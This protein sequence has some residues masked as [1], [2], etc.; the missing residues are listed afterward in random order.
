MPIKVLSSAV[1]YQRVE[2]SGVECTR[3]EETV[4]VVSTRANAHVDQRAAVASGRV[5][6]YSGNSAAGA[7]A[8]AP[9]RVNPLRI[10]QP[11]KHN[12]TMPYARNY[13]TEAT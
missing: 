13:S 2:W 1:I 5:A 12:Y 11:V 6:G 4:G 10:S 8:T 9:C 3:A 7:L